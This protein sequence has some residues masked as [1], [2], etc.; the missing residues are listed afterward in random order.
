[1]M[2]KMAGSSS[3]TVEISVNGDDYEFKT[4]TAIKT[5]VTKFKLGEEFDEERLDGKKVKVCLKNFLI[6][7]V[8]NFA[9]KLILSQNNSLSLPWMETN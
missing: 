5:S 4:I 1:M 3:P 8:K 9:V 2:R 7:L 6:L